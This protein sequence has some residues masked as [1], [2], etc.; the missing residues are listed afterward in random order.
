[1]YRVYKVNLNDIQHGEKYCYYKTGANYA[2]V[3]TS[4][5]IK[6]NRSLSEQEIKDLRPEERD[7][8]KKS[9]IKVNAEHLKK[10]EMQYSEMIGDFFDRLDEELRKEAK[11]E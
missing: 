11:A 10:N 2:L 1:M 8:L 4:K 9:K 7:W 6:G 3:F 5:R